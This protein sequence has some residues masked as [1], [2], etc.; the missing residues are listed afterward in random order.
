MRA[1]TFNVNSLRARTDIVFNWLKENSPDVL[2]LQETKM[3][4]REFPEGKFR[5]LGYYCAFRGETGR[6][7]VAT[8]SKTPLEKVRIGFDEKGSEGDRIITA[9]VRGIP[10]VNTYVPQ[11]VSPYS[12]YFREKLDWLQ[13]LYD[14]FKANF[15]P[16]KPLLWMGDFNIAPEA[17]DVYDPEFLMGHVCFN[18]DVQAALERFR[19]WG[20]E[21]VFRIHHQNEA[22]QYTFWDYQIKNALQKKKGWRLDHIW[23][24]KPLAKKSTGAWIDIGP[25]LQKKPSDHTFLMAEFAY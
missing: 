20:M 14:Y 7:G 5:E 22:G 15:R 12:D 18:A 23:A 25:R 17:I 9:W 2:C 1:A 21:D 10:V 4:D 8:L 3:P 24:T 19:K 13:R 6:N 11:G 16:D